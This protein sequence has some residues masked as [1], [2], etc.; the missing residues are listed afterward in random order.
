[1]STTHETDFQDVR[2]GLRAEDVFTGHTWKQQGGSGWKG[3]C[4]WH[5][6][7]S[8]TCFS[9]DPD[10]LA[11]HC[12]SCGRKGGP[13]EYVAESEGIRRPLEGKAFINAWNALSEHTGCPGPP[14]RKRARR[15]ER[16]PLKQLASKRSKTRRA[17]SAS[18]LGAEAHEAPTPPQGRPPKDSGGHDERELRAALV[19]YRAALMESDRARAYVQSR[20]LSVDTLH[21]YGCGYAAPGEWLQDTG[22]NGSKHRA[23]AGRIVTPHTTPDGRLVNLYGREASS[24][25]PRWRKHRHL[26]GPKGVFNAGAIPDGSGPLVVCESSLDAL[27]FIE[28]GHARTVAV[29][30]KTGLP[31]KA[32]RGNVGAVVIALDEDAETEA[33]DTAR[34]A[35]LRGYEAHLMPPD[36]YGGHGDPNAA[37]QEGALD[38]S[39][40]KGLTGGASQSEGGAHAKEN[41]PPEDAAETPL[42]D[43]GEDSGSVPKLPPEAR[44][45]ARERPEEWHP[46]APEDLIPYWGGNDIGVLGEWLWTHPEPIPDGPLHCERGFHVD[47]VLKK[48]I[49]QT[50]EDGPDRTEEKNVK[51]LRRVLLRLYAAFSEEGH[52]PPPKPGT[53]VEAPLK[54]RW[55]TTGTVRESYFDERR[56]CF[57]VAVQADGAPSREADAV[58]YVNRRD[59]AERG[60]E[61]T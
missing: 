34:E 44:I 25:A 27:S 57:R 41:T 54:G 6:S 52:G 55:G 40:V 48:W 45:R 24:D 35:V 17:A 30:G 39:Y 46:S 31:W 2:R 51:R 16:D 15:R 56:L 28:A 29:H 12:F 61:A 37:L 11:W 14:D 47:F 10:T 36:A 7:K 20:G 4:P 59:V 23:P 43:G 8:G 9:V 32:L 53:P 21:R 1:M 3:S 13:L 33:V 19:R 60:T 22:P 58:Q 49:V 38:V 26:D 5:D 18:R 50:L 42:K